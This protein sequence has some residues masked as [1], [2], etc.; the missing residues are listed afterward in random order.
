MDRF[1]TTP[2]TVV[3]DTSRS[4]FSR[5]HPVPVSMVVLEDGFWRSRLQL[6]SEVTIPAQ[7]RLL[8]KTGRLD[9]FRRVF[10]EVQK[11]YSGYVFNDSDVYKWLESASWSLAS[12]PTARTGGD[13]DQV[14]SLIARA[15]DKDGYLNTYFSL[16]KIRQRWMNLRDMHELYCAGHLIQAAITHHRVTGDNRLLEV[17]LRLADHICTT[18]G[19]SQVEGTCG[20]PEIEMAL[21][22]LYRASGEKKYLAQAALFIDR[23][24][25]GL[26]EN[27]QYLLDHVP[28]RQ[29]ERLTGHA[30]RALYLCSGVTDLALETGEKELFQALE[31]LWTVMVAQQMYVTG[32]VGARHDEEA[33]GQPYELPNARA[34]AESCAAIA[35]V[36]WNWR[37]LQV[38]GSSRYAD[39]MEWALYN[40]V[41]PGISVDALQYFYVNPLADNG[42][43][44][45]QDWFDCACCPPNI[46]RL[47]AQFPGYIYSTSQDGIWVHHYAASTATIELENGP[48]IILEQHTTYP[49]DGHIHLQ[50][51]GLSPVHGALGQSPVSVKFTLFLRLPAWLS[52]Q[53]AA[54]RINGRLYKHQADSGSYLEIHRE[55]K[56]GDRVD[57]DLPLEV[58]FLQS[59]PLVLENLGRVAVAR[60]PLLYCLEAVDNPHLEIT[61]V[62]VD[63]SLAVETHHHSSLLGGITSLYLP[64]FSRMIDPGW[65]D[66]LYRSYRP[67]KVKMRPRQVRLTSM[68]YYAWA[69]R[70]PGAM[71]VWHKL[72]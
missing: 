68:P 41:L 25:H 13:I 18:F 15:Q 66:H 29:M 45:R 36:M 46:A 19:P 44:R 72:K 63:P 16:E 53:K 64:G 8:E 39:L 71:A 34:Y 26:L 48:G 35:N 37:L 22:E 4:P 65:Q 10:G 28:F 33:F 30:V 7:Y 40:A 67:L 55:W 43:H 3:A 23:R 31:R 12:N 60:G 1:S 17:A 50:V 20:H 51:T 70:T 6:N 59:H 61:G 54:V 58:R 9:N 32:G 38:A 14:I 49:W 62:V 2:G 69:N 56:V 42:A 5:L 57:L 24:G 11:P 47:L 27:R 21:V 52:H